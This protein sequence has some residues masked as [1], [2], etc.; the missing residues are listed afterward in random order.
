MR[1]Q[2]TI[3]IGVSGWTYSPWRGHFYPQGLAHK[4][5]L[6]FAAD[7]FASIEINGTFYRLQRPETFRRW[8]AETPD[9]FVFA[10]K[11]PRYI[12][13][14]RRLRE[15]EA[16]LANFFASG[17]LELGPKLGPVLWQFPA[18]F[19]FDAARLDDFLAQLPHDAEAALALARK[20]DSRLPGIE[21]PDHVAA[22]RVRH[23]VE[24][25]HDSFRN[26]DFIEMLRHR[27][28]ALVCADTVEWPRLMDLTAD[29]AYL[30]LHGSE[31]LYRS[32]YSEAALDRWAR[33]IR[34]F[35]DGKPAADA[36]TAGP[37]DAHPAPRDVYVYFDNTDKRHAP[38]DARALIHKL[39]L[40][41]GHG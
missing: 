27:R 31:E 30:R 13:H 12:T 4:H 17:V 36:D 9:D 28:V 3:R 10:V 11:G 20:H 8:A 1:R 23:G 35:A 38:D 25:R 34:A 7:A 40:A 18:S 14:M 16:P 6:S 2:G 5:E 33:L 24:I 15:P 19:A 39:G 26:G 32:G 22:H 37:P 29:F 21:L 41:V